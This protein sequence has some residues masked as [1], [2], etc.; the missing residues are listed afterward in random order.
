MGLIQIYAH[1]IKHHVWLLT[2][3]RKLCP[4]Q[5]LGHLLS[6]SKIVHNFGDVVFTNMPFMH[7]LECN[8]FVLS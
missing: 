6:F 7:S 4:I 1:H 8:A 2:Q 3:Q 5:I